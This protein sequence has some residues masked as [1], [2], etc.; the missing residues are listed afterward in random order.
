MASQDRVG[1]GGRT[2]DDGGE[3]GGTDVPAG[4]MMYH[5][6][7]AEERRRI[8]SIYLDNHAV[9]FSATAM[10]DAT[11]MNAATATEM[12][13]SL[14]AVGFLASHT[15]NEAYQLAGSDD[16]SVKRIVGDLDDDVKFYSLDK[17]SDVVQALAKADSAAGRGAAEFFR[18]APDVDHE[19]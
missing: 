14:E 18:T 15:A 4:Q 12:L 8:V 9:V 17:G 1:R 6:F 7:S 5:L 10:A 11:N 2:V 16:Q 3:E 19:E 13:N